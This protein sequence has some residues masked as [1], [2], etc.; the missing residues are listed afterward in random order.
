MPLIDTPFKKVAVKIVEPIAPPSEAGHLYT[1]TLVDYATRY[2]E[3]VP[4]RKITT[5]AAAEALFD[6]Y[7]RMGIPEEVLTIQGTQL[8]PS[9]CRK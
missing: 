1:L 4:L 3:T 5:E 2:P 6:I 8:C 7:S 9:A